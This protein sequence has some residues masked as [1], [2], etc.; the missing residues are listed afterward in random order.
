[1]NEGCIAC[2]LC[3]GLCPEVFRME[4]VAIVIEGV[5]Y[6]DYDE[7]VKDAADNCPVEVIKY[8]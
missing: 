6:A 7:K 2:G 8:E 1:M 3:E 4:D 5:S